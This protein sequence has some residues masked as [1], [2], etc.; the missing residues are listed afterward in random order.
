M[1]YWSIALLALMLLSSCAAAPS[2][3]ISPH[4]IEYSGEILD[5]GADE[6]DSKKC[7]VLGD[8]MMPDYYKMRQQSRLIKGR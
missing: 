1:K 5:R 7:P 6:I 4:V 8:I 3:A 2:K